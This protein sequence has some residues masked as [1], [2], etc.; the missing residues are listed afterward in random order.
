M[1]RRVPSWLK[2][3]QQQLF[4]VPCVLRCDLQPK[5]NPTPPAPVLEWQLLGVLGFRLGKCLKSPKSLIPTRVSGESP[6]CS[7]TGRSCSG[8]ARQSL[9][10]F[11][12]FEK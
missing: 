9:L 5:C 8:D 6:G 12:T 2:R 11:H 1:L 4:P 10:H 7:E 3:G